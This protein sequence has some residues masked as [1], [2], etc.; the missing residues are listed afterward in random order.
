MPANAVIRNEMPLEW[1][2]LV[3]IDNHDSDALE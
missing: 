3:I 2:L 1:Y